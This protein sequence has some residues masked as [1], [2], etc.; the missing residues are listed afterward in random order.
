M[1][2]NM[3]K[4]AKT[5]IALILCV[6]GIVVT[7]ILSIVFG[8][9]KSEI[10]SNV[11]SIAAAVLGVCTI[12]AG[13]NVAE[14]G[15]MLNP[16]IIELTEKMELVEKGDLSVKFEGEYGI[17][18]DLIDSIESMLS[19]LSDYVKDIGHVVRNISKG[20]LT[21]HKHVNYQGD[22][23]EIERAL[24]DILNGLNE[25]IF[26][27]SS[28]ADSVYESS[29]QV[30]ESSKQVAEGATSQNMAITELS[31]EMKVLED[32]ISKITENTI[33]ANK[34]SKE[35]NA[36]LNAGNDKMKNVVLAMEKID[37]TSD[38]IGEIIGT[39]NSIAAQTNLLALNASI[40]AARAGEAG[41]GFAVVADEIGELANE[42]AEAS[43]NIADLINGSKEAV[44]KGKSLVS[45][46]A[47]SIQLG[48]KN[49]MDLGS[50]LKEIVGY[51]DE[52]NEA[53]GK[54]STGVEDISQVIETN[55]S[56]SEENAATSEELISSANVLKES[57]AKF[58]LRK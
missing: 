22:F 2:E 54:I 35:T 20:N 11:C 47:D 37:S 31:D 40:E 19:Q 33:D 34:I 44:E 17:Y 8:I 6:I 53:L 16:T 14:S 23:K 36:Q 57:V 42:S 3:E 15:G 7:S 12:F 55:A 51:A 29:S 9:F 56:M 39:I 4:G 30:K 38:K 27:V 50:K 21:V 45:D 58:K 49:S 26:Q 48:V 10:L 13:K 46:T 1:N 41:K 28:N 5:S 52:Q 32:K 25:T 24:D 43:S 18:Q